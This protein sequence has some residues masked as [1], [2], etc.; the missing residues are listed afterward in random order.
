M[1]AESSKAASSKLMTFVELI[2]IEANA[3]CVQVAGA[4]VGA[5]VEGLWSA[6][7]GGFDRC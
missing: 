7:L 1:R 2:A 4:P 6:V 5:D 3:E